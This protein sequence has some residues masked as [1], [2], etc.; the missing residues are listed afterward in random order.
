MAVRKR[1]IR[2]ALSCAQNKALKRQREALTTGINAITSQAALELLEALE[3]DRILTNGAYRVPNPIKAELA[4][5]LARFF[6]LKGGRGSGKSFGIC[7]R[8]IEHSF[9]QAFTNSVILCLR[10]VQK[11]ITDS[12]YAMVKGLIEAI[13]TYRKYF[14]MTKTGITNT[15]TGCRFL[16]MGMS[17]SQGAT[18]HN[19]RDKIRSLYNVKAIFC[20]EAQALAMESLEVL[21]P[22]VDR[23]ANIAQKQSLYTLAMDRLNRVEIEANCRFYFAMNPRFGDADP[24]MDKMIGYRDHY[25]SSIV[26][27]LHVNITDLEP[28]A[29]SETLLA[30]MAADKRRQLPNFEHIWLGEP[31]ASLGAAIFNHLEVVCYKDYYGMRDNIAGNDRIYAFIDPATTF[32]NDATSITFMS[33]EGVNRDQWGRLQSGEVVIWGRSW[34]KPYHD[35][36]ND[37]LQAITDSVNLSDKPIEIGIE[38]NAIKNAEDSLIELGIPKRCIESYTTIGSL[39]AGKFEKIETVGIELTHGCS[40]TIIDNVGI[41]ADGKLFSECRRDW[42]KGEVDDQGWYDYSLSNRHWID[43]V[44]NYMPRVTRDD[45]A[46][47]VAMCGIMS[48]I[49]REPNLSGGW[50]ENGSYMRL[51]RS[52]W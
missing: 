47:S 5:P 32:N 13:P 30:M 33:F 8:L 25:G 44:K 46:D 12:T 34:L 27:I 19:T 3:E 40:M 35:C 18:Q 28:Y 31:L 22:T 10:E 50:R 1:T 20:D 49:F 29:Q 43:G 7:V 2:R 6:L 36:L 4:A 15:K 9:E 41:E 48:G 26:K 14:K 16:F 52:R 38:S 24:I 21:F 23:S 17:S 51:A 39:G 11:S 42:I 45:E 37:I